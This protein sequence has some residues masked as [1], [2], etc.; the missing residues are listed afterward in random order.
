MVFLDDI[1]NDKDFIKL[2][3]PIPIGD[4]EPTVNLIGYF[5]YHTKRIRGVKVSS[6]IIKPILR[7]IEHDK[8]NDRN[9][10]DNKIVLVFHDDNAFGTESNFAIFY[11][12]GGCVIGELEDICRY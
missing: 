7:R 1:I 6:V 4:K 10:I 3:H 9:P 8:K 12:D 2:D 11:H 5:P